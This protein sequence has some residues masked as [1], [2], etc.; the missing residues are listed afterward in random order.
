MPR[1]TRKSGVGPTVLL[2]AAL[3]A[4]YALGACSGENDEPSL[5]PQPL[6]PQPGSDQDPEQGRG[7]ATSDPPPTD[8]TSSSGSSGT[9][10]VPAA[11]AAADADGGQ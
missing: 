3:A 6:P 7:G 5:N 4:S 10:D 1:R 2:L 9:P 8:D 11:D